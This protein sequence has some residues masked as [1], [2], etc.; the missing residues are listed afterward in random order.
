MTVQ[1]T[2]ST[3]W[4]GEERPVLLFEASPLEIEAEERRAVEALRH[5]STLITLLDPD[6]R[7]LFSNPAAFAAYGSAAQDFEGRFANPVQAR[8]MLARVLAGDPTAEIG[9]MLTAAGPRWH[10]LDAREVLDPVTGAAGVLLNELDVTE[11]IEAE[12]AKAAAEQKAAM[13]QARQRFLTDMSHELRTPL[14]AVIG[15]SDLLRQSGLSPEQEEQ[16]QRIHDSGK[17]LIS[18]VNEMIHLSETQGWTGHRDAGPPTITKPTRDTAGGAEITVEGDDYPA[19]R[20]LYVDD[21]AHNRALV[22]AILATQG[23]ACATAED[24]DDGLD[25][26]RGGCW[27]LILMDIQMPRMDGVK[28]T[29]AI[30]ALPAPAGLVP[31]LAVTANTLPNQLASYSEAGMN[32]CI[33]KPIEVASLLERVAHWSE[34]MLEHEG[35]LLYKAS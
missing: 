14:N 21:N 22:T 2:I 24:G 11:R 17:V 18:V 12:T 28:S 6:G 5:T 20:V 1:A 29:R 27:D 4:L 13:A 15:F 25:L 19:L 34:W 3:Y 31:I 30:R 35:H 26:A 23:I 16:A 32:D 33:S 9:G 7:V 10:H 8:T